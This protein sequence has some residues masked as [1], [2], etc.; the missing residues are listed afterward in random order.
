[1]AKK[2]ETL[3]L[4]NVLIVSTRK[5]RI[6]GCEE[7]T[8]GFQNNGHGNEVVD[9][10]TMDAK[11]IIKCY[12]IKVTLQDL[13]SNAKK[14][15]YG[16]YNYLVITPELYQSINDWNEYIPSY[17]GIIIGH[18]GFREMTLEVVKKSFKRDLDLT[19]EIMIKESM[20]RSMYWKMEK[21]KDSQCLDKQKLLKSKLYKAEKE[22]D[23]YY[24]R[25]VYAENIISDYETYK[26]AND[27][28]IDIDLER[29]VKE[30]RERINQKRQLE[31]C[32]INS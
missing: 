14:S 25:A 1:M 3:E 12:E 15:W 20:I 19:E 22:R 29:W 13:N 17:V 26:S 21:Y 30:E 16:N 8:I 7:I 9:F 32:Q 2:K 18:Q 4:E 28:L 11:G 27:G 6:Y 10:A 31:N 23:K 5:K 24:K